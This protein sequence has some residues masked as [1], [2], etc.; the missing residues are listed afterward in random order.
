MQTWHI[1]LTTLAGEPVGRGR[2]V[3]RYLLCWL[4]FLPAL[5]AIGFS[6]LRGSVPALGAVLAGVL[7]YAA[8]ARL[9]PQRQFWHDA[10]CGT[11]LVT[12]RPPKRK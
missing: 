12:W 6:G 5:A 4:W 8:L 10:V 2:A 7:A 1:R 9:H 11:M 3:A